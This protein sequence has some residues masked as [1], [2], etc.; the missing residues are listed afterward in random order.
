MAKSKEH[1][2]LNH[3]QSVRG[4]EAWYFN[5]RFLGRGG[6]GT[7]F[8]VSSSSGQ[9]FG[10][11]F[12]LKVFHRLSSDIRRRAFLDEMEYLRTL[13][14]PAIIDI[15]DDGE[16]TVSQNDGSEKTY[17][18]AVVEYVPNTARQLLQSKDVDRIKAVRIA[19]NCLSALKYIH[20]ASPSLIHRDIKPENILIS[21]ATAKLADFGL[22]K[23]SLEEG[24]PKS[25][26]EG[27]VGSQ[28]PGMPY[29]YRTPELVE[30]ARGNDI[31]IT[32]SSDIFQMGTVLYELVTGYNPQTQADEITD[33]IELDVR[34]IKG[35]NSLRLGRLIKQMLKLDPTERPSSE[36]C[37][38]QLNIVHKDLCEEY[39]RVT[40]TEY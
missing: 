35:S 14:H 26:L 7:A 39:L 17:P 25:A 13:E 21:Q 10:L 16:F 19:G 28:W 31:E 40:G 15:Y 2:Y 3:L 27:V 30:K 37:L 24:S 22:V 8:L 34:R 4:N 23:A 9:H 20:A 38:N 11:Q 29:R 1:F 12:V 33:T 5:L 18:F 36:D 6:N 32:T